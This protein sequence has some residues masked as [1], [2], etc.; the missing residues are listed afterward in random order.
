MFFEN[1]RRDLAAEQEG[2][3]VSDE[4]RARL[5]EEAGMVGFFCFSCSV[6]IE[7]LTERRLLWTGRHHGEGQQ[8]VPL[9]PVRHPYDFSRVMS[10]MS[11]LFCIPVCGF[12]VFT[13][14]FGLMIRYRVEFEVARLFAEPRLSPSVEGSGLTQFRQTRSLR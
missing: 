5:A 9:C 4:E 10:I 2:T 14:G 1:R 13:I 7:K 6:V 11:C 8:M 3:K 12:S